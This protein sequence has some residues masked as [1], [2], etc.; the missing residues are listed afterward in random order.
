MKEVGSF[1]AKT[2]FSE[3]LD[4]V[5]AG[6]EIIITR[7]GKEAARLVPPKGT[8]NRAEARAAAAHIRQLAAQAKLG[9]FDWTEW[10][11][12]HDEGRR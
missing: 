7:H 1:E 4:A 11:A 3:W 6:E 12:Y 8:V 9:K 2:K 10:K 5:A